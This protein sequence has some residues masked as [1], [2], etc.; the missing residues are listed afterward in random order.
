MGGYGAPMGG[1]YGGGMYGG[2]NSFGMM[3]GGGMG[4]A[5][6]MMM[7]GYPQKKSSMFS[8]SNVLTGVALYGMYRSMTGGFGGGGGGYGGGYNNYG[9]RE[10]HIYDHRENKPTDPNDLKP[11]MGTL[12]LPQSV[13]GE[14]VVL[15]A[16]TMEEIV[17]QTPVQNV[18]AADGTIVEDPLPPLPFDNQPKIY[19]GY[20]YAYGYQNATVELLSGKDGR[21][22]GSLSSSV[23]VTVTNSENNGESSATSTIKPTAAPEEVMSS[24]TGDELRALSTMESPVE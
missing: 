7:M 18:T 11:I 9:P 19:F 17:A 20:G 10:V 4:M 14:A 3:G 21:K 2:G 15:P 6:G 12:G 22:I 23:P 1:G 5:P 16:K 8:L 13:T 24:T